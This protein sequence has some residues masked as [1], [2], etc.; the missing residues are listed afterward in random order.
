MSK[1]KSNFSAIPKK[2][3]Q[4]CSTLR[5][6][7]FVKHSTRIIRIIQNSNVTFD[8]SGRVLKR[9]RKLLRKYLKILYSFCLEKPNS[10]LWVQNQTSVQPK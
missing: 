4:F 9:E 3:G 1:R 6:K 10:T 8:V 2:H 5:L 7:Q